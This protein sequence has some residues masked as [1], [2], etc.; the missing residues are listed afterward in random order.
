MIGIGVDVGGTKMAVALVSAGGAVSHLTV[1]PT[2]ARSGP[3]VLIADLVALVNR[4]RAQAAEPV[5]WLGVAA[6]GAVDP[7]TARRA[8]SA[9]SRPRASSAATPHRDRNRAPV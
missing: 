5:G 6:A 8:G 2:P 7:S 3:A 4:V 9:R 1:E